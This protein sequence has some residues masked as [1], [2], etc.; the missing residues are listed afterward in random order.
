[1][2]KEG[3][4]VMY[5]HYFAEKEK[6]YKILSDLPVGKV[7]C[8]G[9]NYSEHA[10]ELGNDVPAEPLLFMKPATA[11]TSIE[12]PIVLQERFGEVHYECELALLV[13]ESFSCVPKEE[14]KKEDFYYGLGLDLT[15][16][17]VQTTLKEAG[18]P[19]EKAK[20]FDGSCVLTP[21]MRAE[22]MPDFDD[23]S[24]VF[25]VNGEEKQKGHTFMMMMDI[26][27]LVS[28]TSQIFTLMPG[29]VVLTGT[30][31]GVG[32]LSK[33]DSLKLTLEEF[34]FSGGVI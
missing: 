17:D 24:F 29:D 19:W 6:N 9:R 3:D 12:D 20:A 32:K 26:P 18:H 16:R 13:T 22:E 10:K 11:I 8:I 27:S 23:I 30:P 33:E 28:Y 21:F 25:S 5:Q 7:V 31:K 1:M 15:R 4:C 2:Q 14:I 34:S